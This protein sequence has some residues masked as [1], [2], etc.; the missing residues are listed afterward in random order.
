M[1]NKLFLLLFLALQT[2]NMFAIT[3]DEENSFFEGWTDEQYSNYEDSLIA[4]LY[5]MPVIESLD[6][7]VVSSLTALSATQSSAPNSSLPM[8]VSINPLKEVGQI[9]ITSGFS[10]SGAKTYEIPLDV[11]PGM[12]GFT[13]ALSLSY[14]S[15]RGSSV[16]GMGWALS[17]LS[18]IVRSGKSIYYDGKPESVNMDNTDSFWLDG[19]R[20]ILKNS[21]D[22]Y[23]L[24]ESER[25]YIMAKGYKIGDVIS[26]FDVFYP[27]G[28]KGVYGFTDSDDNCLE[29]PI[30]E[31]TDIRNNSI[32][33][34]YVKQEND[35][36]IDNIQ[37]NGVKVSFN[38][39]SRTDYILS[40]SGGV[41]SNV[42]LL[43][44]KITCSLGSTEI[45]KY[46]LT[47]STS[48][49]KSVLT[50]IEYSVGNKSCNPI[51]F[52]YGNGDIA[53]A[54]NTSETLLYEW[55]KA[56]DISAIRALRGKFDYMSGAEGIITLP[57][58][59]PYWK[60]HRSAGLFNHSEKSFKNLYN[61]E[62]R[63]LLYT[64]LTGS[65]VTPMPNLKTEA[66]FIDIICADIAGNQEDY[67]IKINNNVV[68]NMDVVTF[69]VYCSSVISGISKLYT[70]T[71][72]FPTVYT[73]ASDVKS[74]QPKFYYAGD[75]D[76][77]GKMEI[78]AVSA[79]EPFEDTSKP[80][81]CYIFD[82]VEDKI[83]FQDAVMAYNIDF[84]GSDNANSEDIENRSDKL[85]PM[86]I[87]GDGKTEICH[88]H[89]NGMDIYGFTNT[90]GIWKQN[91]ISTST[92][93]KLNK[94]INRVILTVDYNGDGL[95]DLLVSP[96]KNVSPKSYTWDIFYSK[97]NGQFANNTFTHTENLEDS[98]FLVQD[99]NGDG[100]SDIIKYDS[101]GFLTGITVN[102]NPRDAFYTN[103]PSEESILISADLNAH[104]TYTQLISLK[105]GKATKY[106][107]S[108]DD[109]MEAMLTGMVNSL[110]VVEKNTYKQLDSNLDFYSP[111]NDAVYPFVNAN[112]PLAVLASTETYI[113]GK[114][115]NSKDYNYENAVFHRQGLG[116]CGFESVS[117]YDERGLNF[118]HKYDPYNFGI[119]KHELTPQFDRT[120]TYNIKVSYNKLLEL[121]VSNKTEKDLLKNI[122]SVS[123]Y[124]DNGLGS[125][126]TE[127]T[128]YND[129]I[130]IDKEFHYSY[131]LDVEPGYHRGILTIKETTISKGEDTYTE[132]ESR[133]TNEFLVPTSIT[134]YKNDKAVQMDRYEYDSFGN[135]TKKR[136]SPFVSGSYQDTTY[137]YN[138]YG[139]ISSI[140]NP[141]GLTEKFYYDSY[142]RKE[143]VEDCRGGI[144]KYE[145]DGFGHQTSVSYPDGTSSKIVY[146]WET[147]NNA[148]AVYSL[149]ETIT[150][151]P[152]V[153][154]FYDALNRKVR[155]SDVRFD[156]SI[157]NTDFEYDVHGNLSRQ[158]LPYTGNNPSYWNTY[159][160][161]TFDRMTSFVEA[162]GKKTTYEYSGNSVTVVSEKLSSK[163]SYDSL[164][165][166]T[167]VNDLNGTITYNLDAEG[168]PMSVVA[169]DKTKIVI[170]YDSYG[171]RISLSDPSAGTTLYEYSN[172]S[173]PVKETNANGKS[174]S[175]KY[176]EHF[177]L[178]KKTSPEFS[179]DYTYNDFGDIS[180]MSS[181]NGTSKS[182]SYDNFGRLK[183]LTTKGLDNT[184]LRKD[185]TY[186]D[187]N[188]ST[189]KYTSHNG[190]LTTENY[191]YSNGYLCEGKINGTTSIFKLISE[192]VFGMPTKV[193]TGNITRQY[194][195]T[196]YGMPA[197]RTASGPNM[198]YQ[199]VE[200]NYDVM[201][202]N[203]LSRKDCTRNLKEDFEYYGQNCLVDY[204]DDFVDY[205]SN[206]T[207]LYK[208]D[209]GAF[210]YDNSTKP[211][212]MST[213]YFNEGV[214]SD[215]G[216]VI[217]YTSFSRPSSIQQ[218]S[219]SVTF[220]YDC[221]YN[222]VR[223][224]M[225]GQPRV[226]K[227][228]YGD[229]YELIKSVEDDLLGG[230][231]EKES[232]YLFGN[233]YKASAVYQKEGNADNI[234]FMLH[235]N[236][237]SITHV[238]DSKNNYSLL[239]E[240]SYNPWGNPRNPDNQEIDYSNSFIAD[241]QRGYTGHEHLSSFGLINM[242]ARLYE[243]A[244]SN[245]LS[246]D[247]F[248]QMPECSLNF[249]RYIYALNNPFKYKDP[250][251]EFFIFT[252]FNAFIDLITNLSK[253]G[254]NVSQ[255]DWTKTVNSWKIDMG[256]FKGNFGQVLNK[257]TYGLTNSLLG[258]FVA[259]AYNIVGKVDGVTELDGMLALSG[260]TNGNSA[261]TIGHYSFGPDNYKADWRDHLF[262]HEYG[263]YIQSQILGP[264][265][266][267]AIALPSLASAAFTSGISGVEHKSRWFEVNASKLGAN[268]F[269]KKYG[270]GKVGFSTNNPNYFNKMA[271]AL[272]TETSYMNPRTGEN[273][274]HSKPISGY[275]IVIW[276]FIF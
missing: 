252:F 153:T 238:I 182:F 271:F 63:I 246:P 19:I 35:Y 210:A 276:D 180:E 220:D 165:R 12:N 144:T 49:Y 32:S 169:P 1:K 270:S 268:H 124:K 175:Y 212:A 143:R 221:D 156:S 215:I 161:D 67:I 110:G 127:N 178:I 125:V 66:G 141:L 107:F 118:Y 194:T 155:Q 164:G 272:G 78:L 120:F 186:A 116:F 75:F 39:E 54:F 45:G 112:E 84:I 214:L 36:Y 232:L 117:C 253:H 158:S 69:N 42:T 209:A 185:Y 189:I 123:N 96:K 147:S 115:T 139:Q 269:D 85:I 229:C 245:F 226:Y 190:L 233:Y 37:Y 203:L 258:N 113:N 41:A 193:K 71:Y 163:K 102:L 77:D 97:G 16:L 17:G 121:F 191:L 264:R 3:E 227:Y 192:N 38:Y 151:K 90:Y 240:Y 275:N 133:N 6:S 131:K 244:S 228:Y 199:D 132:H 34:S 204:G 230:S 98:G 128:V 219:K 62:E 142:G 177:R 22:D 241:L 88:I 13:P 239:N 20:L 99:V 43:L 74:V 5:P 222:R 91:K 237:G 223:T 256:M 89:S 136:V 46:T 83:V 28:N 40:Y 61:G 52:S 109:H 15:H 81:K 234:L 254:V 73:D 44:K 224:T 174:I 265:Y 106:S 207:I 257:I 23:N 170:E 168:K 154:T 176:D 58:R 255:Y 179:T 157:V 21:A 9:N 31:F 55:Y 236:I 60:H 92:D 59:N 183:S 51:E 251:G 187:G 93:L 247:P 160:Y 150:G 262:V 202:S 4:S 249:N 159:D 137:T 50:R 130:S 70:R 218:G 134:Y 111:G 248:V 114:K 94:L 18:K 201:T 105:E 216:Q 195:Y 126:Y 95:M 30:T 29:Y 235:D 206:G 173:M 68:D 171:R 145:Y 76:G 129:G 273:S 148:N 53:N 211:H 108:R 167:S 274:D 10:Q 72:S 146:S 200:Y 14:N 87:N 64:G 82:L 267:I 152:K 27:D 196:E 86:D 7:S 135:I 243:P 56:E 205:N 8:S 242:N 24:Y 149:T 217:S 184:W 213:G 166:L 231:T 162:S 65:Y 11:F 119:L 80:S 79:N 140:T 104:D 25:G 266:L 101:K 225:D 260:T 2:I 208:S 172:H 197:S 47:Y 103:F 57:N 261:F 138:A 259:E 100:K 26:Y 188:I 33:Y 198:V 181:T 122:S 250:N 48:N 263:H